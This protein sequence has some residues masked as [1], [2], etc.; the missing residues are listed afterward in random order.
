M[1]SP[2]YSL[3]TGFKLDAPSLMRRS[4]D[5]YLG[6]ANGRR[7]ELLHRVVAEMAL[8]RPLPKGAIVHHIDGD[9]LN[10]FSSNLLVCPDQAYHKLIHQRADALKAC[11]HADWL[12][13]K[14]CHQ[15]DAP[16][17]LRIYEGRRKGRTAATRNIHHIECNKIYL[18]EAYERRASK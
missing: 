17:N 8:G 11:G 16:E 14:F 10:N 7:T 5:G 18:R 6:I 4:C 2:I 13:C 1:S 9:K 12:K 3:I 15:Y